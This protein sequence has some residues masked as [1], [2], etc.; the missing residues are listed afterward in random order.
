[1]GTKEQELF[2]QGLDI[3]DEKLALPAKLELTENENEVFITVQEGRFHQV[4][5][6]AQAVGRN[7]TYLKRISM[8]NLVLDPNLKKGEYRS[9]TEKELIS[10]KKK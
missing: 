6:M 2:L 10:L 4:K 7:V 5:R 1:M 9:L 3:G 8:G